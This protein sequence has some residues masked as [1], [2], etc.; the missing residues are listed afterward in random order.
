MH[1][2]VMHCKCRRGRTWGRLTVKQLPN[3]MLTLRS[4]SP[5]NIRFDYSPIYQSM[6]LLCT[7]AQE[8]KM[9]SKRVAK[10]DD[11]EDG[12]KAHA[13]DYYFILVMFESA[14]EF[15]DVNSGWRKCFRDLF[16]PRRASI[17]RG[18]TNSFHDAG[19]LSWLRTDS[20]GKVRVYFSWR[21]SKVSLW[22]KSCYLEVIWMHT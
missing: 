5:K 3:R 13:Y 22:V 10:N 11:W 20:M 15:P 16:S 6:Q 14:Q 2:K 21:I 1:L 9:T 12:V 17:S 4:G 8:S 18:G 7:A 19:D